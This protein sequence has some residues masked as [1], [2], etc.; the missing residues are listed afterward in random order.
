MSRFSSAPGRPGRRSLVLRVATVVA[1][2]MLVT[3]ATNALAQNDDAR[4][5]NWSKVE[6]A[7]ET[8]TYREAIRVGGAFDAASRGFLE[9]I[10]LPQLELEANRTTIERVRKRLREFLLA[11][12]ASDKVADEANKACLSF[13]QSL[14]A[15][16]D[17]DAVVRVNAMLMIGELQSVDRKPWQPA[18]AVLAQA[19]ANAE[20][21]KAVRIAACV[22]L[23]R[24]VE[25][26]KGVVEEQQRLAAVCAGA[27]QQPVAAGQQ[28]TAVWQPGTAT[29]SAGR[30]S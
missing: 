2:G 28:L 5:A 16:E 17:A 12:F 11:D 7:A 24:H 13:M 18:A 19:A 29:A 10:A 23:A 25:G 6:S 30:H 8:R 3:A 4:F 21:P 22:G 20:L 26:T 15:K 27:A 14:A 9:E 1:A